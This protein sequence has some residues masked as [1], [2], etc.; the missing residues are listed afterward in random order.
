M[1][2]GA[3]IIKTALAVV[4]CIMIDSFIKNGSGFLAGVAAI[5]TMQSTFKDS[6]RK[7]GHR[8]L[9]TF[10][11]AILGGVF[12]LISQGNILLIAL[13]I[14]ILIYSFKLLKWDT[15]IVISCV[16][17][18]II[19]TEKGNTDIL[20]YSF[21]RLIDTTLG[22]VIA[23]LVNYFIKPPKI[24]API[25]DECLVLFEN[26]S[27]NIDNI[28]YENT[29]IDLEDLQIKVMDLK[30]KADIHDWEVTLQH[31]SEK[32]IIRIKETIDTLST[33]YE[34]LLFVED[35]K[36]RDSIGI[37]SHMVEDSI[38][39]KKLPDIILEFHRQRVLKEYNKLQKLLSIKK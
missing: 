12:A 30:R 28:L 7:G 36:Q 18:L 16:V 25:Y 4:L 37:P 39:E 27:Q 5:I 38:P 22:I 3:R 24:I 17:F 34:H 23:L 1:K 15:G 32:E 31:E 10:F 6:F 33:I 8:I 2:I 29:S 21:F 11:G 20:L 9:G 19:M 14:I 26:L 35:L 13:G